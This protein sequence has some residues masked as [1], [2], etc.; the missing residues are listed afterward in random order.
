MLLVKKFR[1]TF[2]N[3]AIL[4]EKEVTE[5]ACLPEGSIRV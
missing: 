1:M 5:W 2:H 3:S 4:C